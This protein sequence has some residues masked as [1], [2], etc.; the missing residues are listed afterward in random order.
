MKYYLDMPAAN[1]FQRLAIENTPKT[2]GFKVFYELD[3]WGNA[4]HFINAM[5]NKGHPFAIIGGAWSD[6]HSFDYGINK[7][8]AK[9]AERMALKYPHQDIYFAPF[10]EHV[11][12]TP[13]LDM[14]QALSFAP[15]CT[16][17]NNPGDYNGRSG[18]FSSIF[19]NEV[20]KGFSGV[21][22]GHPIFSYDGKDIRNCN[23]KYDRKYYAPSLMGGWIPQFNRKRSDDD[24]TP[25]QGR[26]IL[27]N[28]V[29]FQA[30]IKKLTSF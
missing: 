22:L 28:K 18:A 2:F 3:V 1:T 25:R 9:F 27:P 13:D 17:V 16:I 20:H 21:P 24:S 26:W 4:E 7:Q 15:N 14:H 23:V 12:S 10:V 29:D 11:I 30:C 8:A 19:L 6:N 5:L